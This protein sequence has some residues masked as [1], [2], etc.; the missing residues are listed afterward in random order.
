MAVA[1]LIEVEGLTAPQYDQII[2][3]VW[4]DGRLPQNAQ[5]HLAGPAGNSWRV[6]DVWDS[7]DSFNAFVQGTLGAAMQ[8][9][10]VTVQPR[11][12]FWP[13]HNFAQQ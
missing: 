13:L 3:E 2:K 11:I 10:G 4:P 9:A 7:A 6:V 1:V 5:F 12:D 8:N